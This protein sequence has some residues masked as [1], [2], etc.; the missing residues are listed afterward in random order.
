MRADFAFGPLRKEVI[1]EENLDRDGAGPVRSRSNDRLG[2]RIQRRDV[3][4]G[5]RSGTACDGVTSCGEQGSRAGR[6]EGSPLQA[7]GQGWRQDSV[8]AAGREGCTGRL[9]QLDRP[10]ID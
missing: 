3:G 5:G 10:E 1:H 2:M 4:V 9:D 7:G 8:A 6:D